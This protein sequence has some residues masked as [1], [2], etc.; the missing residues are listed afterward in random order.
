MAS[1]TD[2]NDA[3]RRFVP[4]AHVGELPR[5]G[6]LGRIVSGTPILLVNLAGGI[7]AFEDRCA[8][9]DVR[10]C[11]GTLEGTVLTCR[12]HD[13]RYD[14]G[15]GCGIDRPGVRLRRYPMQIEGTRILVDVDGES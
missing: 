12:A 15:T 3:G 1:G 13:W 10:L 9:R 5:G 2:R 6:K 8:H 4:V 14:A 11:E 7:Q